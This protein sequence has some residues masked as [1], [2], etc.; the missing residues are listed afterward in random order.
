MIEWLW[1]SLAGALGALSRYGI[2]Q[3]SLF[4]LHRSWPAT[5]TINLVGSA[6]LGYCLAQINTGAMFQIGFLGAF[7]TFSMF[8]LE[9]TSWA[10]QQRAQAFVY[11]FASVVGC[12]AAFAFGALA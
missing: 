2:T 12:T 4:L 1:I 7:T 9:T 10:K 8:M 11:V 3:L 6:L 5:L